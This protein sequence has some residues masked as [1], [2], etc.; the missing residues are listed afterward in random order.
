[1]N[2]LDCKLMKN[3]IIFGAL[4]LILAILSYNYLDQNIVLT[5]HNSDI[6]SSDQ[7]EFATAISKIFSPKIWLVIAIV[8]TIVCIHNHIKYGKSSNQLY[9]FSL[10]LI[11]AIIITTILKIII[12][13]YRPEALIFDN[14]FGFHF[15]SMKKVYN[16]MPSGHTTLSFAGLLAFANFFEKKWLTVAVILLGIIVAFTRVIIIDH[17]LSDVIVAIYLGTFI[18]LWCKTFVEKYNS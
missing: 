15:F 14:K 3:T 12:A 7:A 10:T 17:Y 2:C 9:T 6:F 4:T 8:A 18:Y 16:S 1:M 11:M 13:R 5:L